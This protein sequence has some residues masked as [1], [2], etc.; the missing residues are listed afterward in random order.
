MVNHFCNN[1]WFDL[2]VLLGQFLALGLDGMHTFVKHTC[3]AREAYGTDHQAQ[4]KSNYKITH[5]RSLYNAHAVELSGAVSV[6]FNG[7]MDSVFCTF[8][9]FL[10]VGKK[11]S[12]VVLG[13]ASGIP[14]VPLLAEV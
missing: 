1:F 4:D 12:R 10:A 8:S 14:S 7:T 6:S 9:Q 5:S 2:P 3:Q 13:N 11:H